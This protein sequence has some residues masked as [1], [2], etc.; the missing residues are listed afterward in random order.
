MGLHKAKAQHTVQ[1]V[2]VGVGVCMC[3]CPSW[4]YKS[5]SWP[6][7]NTL[8]CT[9]HYFVLSDTHRAC[10]LFTL[11]A[12][13]QSSSTHQHQRP[14]HISSMLYS[15][16]TAVASWRWW[17]C[18]YGGPGLGLL[19]HHCTP[20]LKLHCHHLALLVVS[21]YDWPGGR[22]LNLIRYQQGGATYD[23]EWNNRTSFMFDRATGSCR[24]INFTVVGIGSWQQRTVLGFSIARTFSRVRACEE[25]HR[26]M[27]R[28]CEAS[29]ASILT[30][31]PLVKLGPPPPPRQGILRPDWLDGATY[32]GEEDVDNRTTHVFTKEDF[33][34]Y[35]ED[36]H[37]GRPVRWRFH[38]S[39]GLFEVMAFHEG[40]TAPESEWQAPASCFQ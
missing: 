31:Q 6:L 22:N 19:M 23:V 20:P 37:T 25:H 26:A 18:K 12:T 35:Y 8:C 13:R 10:G 38:T 36:V 27:T 3:V 32:L 40:A 5:T 14:G 34:T 16:R 4:H 24:T 9:W 11:W 30:I 7:C 17:T 15:L 2:W 33:I 39:G 21:Y 28:H 1:L 29:S